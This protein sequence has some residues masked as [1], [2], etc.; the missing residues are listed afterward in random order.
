MRDVDADVDVAAVAALIGDRARAAMLLALLDG[1][2]RAAG[3]LA[4]QAGVSA[5]TASQHLGRLVDGGLLTVSAQG[6]HRFYTLAG[7]QVAAAVESLAT[8][9]PRRRVRSLRE[10]SVADQ[11]RR[12]RS[13]YD[14]LAGRAGMAL[15]DAL[16]ERGVVAPLVAGEVGR[17][18]RP[19]HP[20]F[21]ALGVEVPDAPASSRPVVRGCLDWTE[22]RPHVA[23]RLGAALL[24]ALLSQRWLERRPR[25]RALAVTPLGA[26]RLGAILERAPDELLRLDGT[27]AQPS[28]ES[29]F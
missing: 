16:V 6:R 21:A 9:S 19:E 12:A 26:A 3:D 13:C 18:L 11:L 29:A 15:A 2:P 22:R 25:D 24:G 23:G 14:H 1:Q 8:I 5:A 28:A 7:R 27:A 20:L 17:L 4:R 10:A